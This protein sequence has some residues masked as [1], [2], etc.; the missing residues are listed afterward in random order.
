MPLPLLPV[1]AFGVVAVGSAV[2]A[3]RLSRPAPVPPAPEGAPRLDARLPA[4]LWPAHGGE[5]LVRDDPRGWADMLA[6]LAHPA[7]TPDGAERARAVAFAGHR[8]SELDARR[9]VALEAHLLR[10]RYDPDLI[11]A[12][13]L[14]PLRPASAAASRDLRAFGVP[15]AAVAI[16]E[17][18]H[19]LDLDDARIA[20]A[21]RRLA[22]DPVA[23]DF[24]D[25]AFDELDGSQRALLGAVLL[26]AAAARV[27]ARVGR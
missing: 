21:R 22:V 20:E 13:W 14:F 17:A 1:L 12:A 27:A 25:E 7:T 26:D 8:R 9:T 18:A 2:A 16:V 23:P 4:S 11:A 3:W 10:G 6:H 19:D 5:P 15:D 24:G